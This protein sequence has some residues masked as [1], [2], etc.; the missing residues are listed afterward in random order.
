MAESRTV[1][2]WR[3]LLALGCLHVATAWPMAWEPEPAGRALR[4]PA[5]DLLGL[6]AVG[7]AV[8]ARRG[9]GRGIAWACTLGLLLAAA[10]RAAYAAIQLGFDRP[11]R[12]DDVELIDDLTYLLLHDLAT[13]PRVGWLTLAGLLLLGLV[14]A[15]RWSFGTVLRAAAQPRIGAIVLLLL[16]VW[17]M[18]RMLAA[19]AG[20]TPWAWRGSALLALVGHV[21]AWVGERLAPGT[22]AQRIDTAIGQAEA[23]LAALPQDL[24]KLRGTDVFVVFAE[25]YG[26]APFR[27]PVLGER[28][29]ELLR[30]ED[31]RL[32]AAGFGSAT[33]WVRPSI[34]GGASWLAHM[35]MLC[36]MPVPDQRTW[37]R[38]LLSSL[39]PLPARLAAAGW[40]CL[41]VQGG[42]PT[43]WPEGARF[44]GFHDEL[45][46]PQ[47]AFLGPDHGWGPPDQYSLRVLLER[48]AA[49]DRPPLFVEFVT[50]TAHAPF[51]FV[52]R[53]FDDWRAP[54]EQ[55]FVPPATTRP[56]G[57]M[58]FLRHPEVVSAYLETTEYTLR[59]VFGFVALLTRPSLVLIV[60]DHQ[61]PIGAVMPVP[62]HTR[63]VPLHVLSNRADLILPFVRSGCA[64][65]LL[66]PD[67][68]DWLP[69][70]RL[71]PWL[72]TTFGG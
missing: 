37:E 2:V 62:D 15:L 52:P 45:F 21:Q 59:A 27:Q 72:L 64:P 65:G 35:Q 36:G 51:T 11:F 14:V 40:R 50:A 39:R 13:A 67:T 47:L 38:L 20:L 7:V 55:W 63:D 60:G 58:N 46:R 29:G 49:A 12:L 28:L 6:L 17:P 4:Q 33:R 16:A 10:A 34:Y 44:F 9:F 41:T 32:A 3:W 61:P 24:G 22:I 53:L 69:T 43:P 18:Q 30:A 31:A 57:P 26:R 25:S 66:P 8:A 71:L 19:S 5:A 54:R 48:V 68:G 42:M 56:L 23:T 70:D 1:P